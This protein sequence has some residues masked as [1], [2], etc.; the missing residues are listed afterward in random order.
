MKKHR[1]TNQKELRREFWETYPE[2][3][4]KKITDH[5]GKG[6][7]YVVDTRCAFVEFVDSLSRNGDISEKLAGKATL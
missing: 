2:L 3:N 7:M 1:I 4:R 5:S 6:K